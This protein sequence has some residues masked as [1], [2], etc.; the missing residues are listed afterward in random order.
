VREL[1][2]S[3]AELVAQAEKAVVPVVCVQV[4]AWIGQASSSI[5]EARITG[6]LSGTFSLE[7]RVDPRE[8]QFDRTAVLVQPGLLPPSTARAS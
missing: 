2:P 1:A 4:A 5:T 8:L 3:P 6:L 7:S